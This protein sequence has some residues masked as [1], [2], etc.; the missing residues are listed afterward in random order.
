MIRLFTGLR[1][2]VLVLL[3]TAMGCVVQFNTPTCTRDLEC[4][5]G[6]EVCISKRC[7]P[8]K[9][10]EA[11]GNLIPK[12]REDTDLKVSFD[13]QLQLGTKDAVVA[14]GLCPDTLTIGE[15]NLG[16]ALTKATVCEGGV[17][18]LLHLQT[19][20]SA[21]ATVFRKRFAEEEMADA[22]TADQLIEAGKTYTA[23]FTQHSVDQ[24]NA[25]ITNA[26]GETLLTF[27]S[28]LETELY[29]PYFLNELV[30]SNF[31]SAKLANERW[32]IVTLDN[33][34]IVLN[35]NQK[36][37]DDFADGTYASFQYGSPEVKTGNPWCVEQMPQVMANVDGGVMTLEFSSLLQQAVYHCF[38]LRC[39]PEVTDCSKV[40]SS[41]FDGGGGLP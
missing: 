27:T 40:Q 34:N 1:P 25:K 24:Y 12:P 37:V 28:K 4:I 16:L 21:K 31:T 17:I 13:F 23:T 15:V 9:E 35:G 20:N 30:F 19:F 6:E 11:Q 2:L 36:L 26:T 33:V 32:A 18:L 39:P 41:F 38:E 3:S 22:V 14:L 10:A 5:L 8:I 29:E 7:V